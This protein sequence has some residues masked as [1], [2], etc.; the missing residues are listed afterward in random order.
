MILDFQTK[1]K[2]FQSREILE[3][4]DEHL[5]QLANHIEQYDAVKFA[6]VHHKSNMV[7]VFW[8]DDSNPVMVSTWSDIRTKLGHN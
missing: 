5:Q 2:I 1:N 8:K 7:E 4:S 3:M 6:I